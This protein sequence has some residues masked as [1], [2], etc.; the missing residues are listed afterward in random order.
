[1]NIELVYDVRA[2]LVLFASIVI[3][4]KIGYWLAFRVPALA[5]MRDLNRAEDRQRVA[6]DKYPPVIRQ[7]Q[8]IGLAFYGVFFLAIAPFCVTLAPQPLWEALL[9]GFLIL[10]VYDF[11]YYLTHRFL[12]HGPA[13]LK[14]HGLHHQARDPSHIDAFYVHPVETVIGISLFVGTIVG[15]C[16]VLGTFHALTVAACYLI[17]VQINTINH[18]K[19]ELPYFPFR[20]LTW[21]TRKHHVHHENMQKGNYATITLFWDKVFG[22]L[23]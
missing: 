14:V 9:D 13:L 12:F 4:S 17:F 7:N 11:V 8:R 1:M 2:G 18:T 5:R 21:I 3:A 16:A 22:T 10:M 23:D 20:T 6:K 15:M 19:V